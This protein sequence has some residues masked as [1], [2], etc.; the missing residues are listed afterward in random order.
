MAVV[1]ETLARW[2]VAFATVAF[3][4]M[5]ELIFRLWLASNVLRGK[6]PQ[7]A[8]QRWWNR[9]VE[10]PVLVD[11]YSWVDERLIFSTI[12]WPPLESAPRTAER[13]YRKRVEEVLGVIAKGASE[14]LWST[15]WE[16]CEL[17]WD[18]EREVWVDGDGHHYDGA[19]FHDYSRSGARG[20][21]GIADA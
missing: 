16:V 3:D 4:F 1:T 2:W 15:R 11:V 21:G 13:D 10:V 12:V 17:A 5:E 7:K 19:R 14:K 20:E 8:A 18:N 6:V 9:A